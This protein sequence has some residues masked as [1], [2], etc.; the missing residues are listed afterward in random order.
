MSLAS[1][2]LFWLSARKQ[3]QISDAQ[4]YA[5]RFEVPLGVCLFKN[6]FLKS[7]MNEQDS[8][9]E[10]INIWKTSLVARRSVKL[11]TCVIA[12][13]SLSYFTLACG[14][15]SYLRWYAD[16]TLGALIATKEQQ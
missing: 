9:E 12:S 2:Y 10:Q 6:I 7:S 16:L 4:R 11:Y 15:A 1:I 8:W 13:S 3:V 14:I 5:L